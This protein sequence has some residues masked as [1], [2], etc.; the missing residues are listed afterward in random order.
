M[1]FGSAGTSLVLAHDDR[2]VATVDLGADDL[3]AADVLDLG[4]RDAACLLAPRRTYSGRMPSSVL[5]PTALG[6]PGSSIVCVAQPAP[7]VPS[8]LTGSTFMPGE[9]M[10]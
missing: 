6:A 3:V 7:C 4:D 1:T 5:P 9:P 8:M 10:K 2:D